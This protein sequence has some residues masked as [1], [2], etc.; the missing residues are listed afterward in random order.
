MDGDYTFEWYKNTVST[1]R[2]SEAKHQRAGQYAFNLLADIR[3]DISEKIRGSFIDPFY[4]DEKLPAFMA[5]VEQE[6]G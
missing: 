5:A 4:R 1:R 3:P 6:W 2:F